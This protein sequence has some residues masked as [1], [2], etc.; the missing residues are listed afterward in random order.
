MRLVSGIQVQY[1]KCVHCTPHMGQDPELNSCGE[2]RGMC[3]RGF[4]LTRGHLTS[5]TRKANCF[6][7]FVCECVRA[8]IGTSK[9]TQGSG[10]CVLPPKSN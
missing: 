4:L 9:Q 3:N 8:E 2:L 5:H 10:T 7:T 6:N 1:K